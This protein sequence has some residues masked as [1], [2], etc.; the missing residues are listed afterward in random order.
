MSEDNKWYV[1]MHTNKINKKNILELQ[2][3]KII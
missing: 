3:K 1:Y 2:D